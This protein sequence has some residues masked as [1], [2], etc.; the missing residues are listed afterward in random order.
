MGAS[1]PS[2]WVCRPSYQ[3]AVPGPLCLAR[4]GEPLSHLQEMEAT[5]SIWE[6]S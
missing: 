2:S 5:S 6:P 3:P 4:A 1:R